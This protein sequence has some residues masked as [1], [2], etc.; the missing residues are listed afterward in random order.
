MGKFS[1]FINLA[2]PHQLPLYLNLETHSTN[3][4]VVGRVKGVE[5]RRRCF[6]GTVAAHQMIVKQQK[7]F[8]NVVVSR[9]GQRTQQVIDRVVTGL[10]DRHCIRLSVPNINAMGTLRAC[11]NDGLLQIINHK[12]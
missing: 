3:R 6:G 9:Y 12:G 7:Y 2:S 8:R 1:R 11:E 10:P 5:G 4:V